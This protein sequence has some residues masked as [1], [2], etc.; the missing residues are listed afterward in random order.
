M[1]WVYLL[2]AGIFEIVWATGLKFSNGFTKL[3]PTLITLIAMA[4]SFYYLAL[5]TKTLPIGTGYAVWTGIGAVGTVIIGML[6]FNESTALPRLLFL[7]LIIIGIIG[8][9]FSSSN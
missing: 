7:S 6:I 1:A 2:I 5:A 3:V 9:K 4:V 8:L